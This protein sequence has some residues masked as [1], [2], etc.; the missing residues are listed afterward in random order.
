MRLP[1][2]RRKSGILPGHCVK[3]EPW[4]RTRSANA[5]PVYRMLCSALWCLVPHVV[6]GLAT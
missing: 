4:H 3:E 2:S 6:S 1:P 5:N